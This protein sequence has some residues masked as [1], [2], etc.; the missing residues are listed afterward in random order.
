VVKRVKAHKDQVAQLGCVLCD[1]LGSGYTPA[2]LHHIREGQG[3]AQRSSDWL[4]VPLCS[5]CHQGPYG[6]HGDQTMLKIAKVTE[7]DLL[8]ATLERLG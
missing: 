6:V 4:V 1:V 5:S 2:Q 7:L 8:A 3:M